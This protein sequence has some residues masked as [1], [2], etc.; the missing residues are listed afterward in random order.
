MEKI[1]RLEEPTGPLGP[2]V[3]DKPKQVPKIL[4]PLRPLAVN[5]G[6]PA[7]FETRITPTD[8]V[9][10]KVEWFINGRPLLDASRN[11][12]INDF[13]YIALDILYTRLEDF[14]MVSVKVHN[15]MGIDETSAPLTQPGVGPTKPPRFTSSLQNV[16]NAKEG[17]NIHLQATLEPAK[18]PNLTVSWYRNGHPIIH[19]SRVKTIHDFGFVVF[20]IS[21]VYAEDSGNFMIH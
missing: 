19:G 5:E 13:G 20:E 21:P 3:P 11:K 9:D 7:H 12:Q 18:D 14:G 15:S 1:R 2:S 4:S 6:E 17:D 8:D 16:S 10:M